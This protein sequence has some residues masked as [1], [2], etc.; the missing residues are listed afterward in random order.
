MLEDVPVDFVKSRLKKVQQFGVAAEVSRSKWAQYGW[1][2]TGSVKA[3]A[4]CVRISSPQSSPAQSGPASST[5]LDGAKYKSHT[6][7][8]LSIPL[9]YAAIMSPK[10]SNSLFFYFPTFSSNSFSDL[11]PEW[12]YQHRN[13]ITPHPCW[14]CI[15]TFPWHSEH[16]M[17]SW[18]WSTNSAQPGPNIL[19]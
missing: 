7:P 2:C 8:F 18:L 17:S 11:Q 10:Y 15:I 4:V 14:K 6:P 19:S 1:V 3:G 13:Q 5:P 16:N 9:I 12:S